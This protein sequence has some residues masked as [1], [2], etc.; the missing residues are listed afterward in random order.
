[1]GQRW[2]EQMVEIRQHLM[3]LQRAGLVENLARTWSPAVRRGYGEELA[4]VI[5]Q[6]QAL[7]SRI[8][9]VET[10]A[11]PMSPVLTLAESQTQQRSRA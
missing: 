7:A 5:A 1:M 8:A 2:H 4:Q 10:G 6:L 11:T 9:A 3:H